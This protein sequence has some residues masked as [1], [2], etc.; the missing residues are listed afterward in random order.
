LRRSRSCLQVG[1]RQGL[2]LVREPPAGEA[3]QAG[4]LGESGLEQVDEFLPGDVEVG[5]E[6]SDLLRPRLDGVSR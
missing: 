2:L 5:A 1:E 3:E 4:V 6:R